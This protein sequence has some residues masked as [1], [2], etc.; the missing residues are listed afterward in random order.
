MTVAALLL[1][2][3]GHA[4]PDS[5]S[6]QVKISGTVIATASCDFSGSDPIQVDFG[7]VYINEIA[8]G[9]YKQPVPY[10]VS[11]RGDPDG[12]LLQMQLSGTAGNYDNSNLRTSAD[13][14]EIK[15]LKGSDAMAV[16]QWF[17]FDTSNPVALSAVLIKQSGANLKDGQAFSASAT[18]NVAYN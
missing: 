8:A 5:G 9:I 1:S 13:G 12:K 15:L 2:S 18:L 3:A 17:N 7:D 10:T 4:A 11:C 6:V 16:N 14:L